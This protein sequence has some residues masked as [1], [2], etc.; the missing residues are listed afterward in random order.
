MDAVI[1]KRALLPF[2]GQSVPNIQIAAKLSR[3]LTDLLE[4]EYSVTGKVEALR[5]AELAVPERR[6]ALWRTTCFEA[7]VRPGRAKHYR[8]YNFAP[9]R[10]YAIYDFERYREGMAVADSAVPP[11]IFVDSDSDR[12]S[13]TAMVDPGDWWVAGSR[14]GLSAV[15]EDRDGGISHW[16]L[17]HPSEKPDFHDPSC[18]ALQLPA[19]KR[20]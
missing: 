13:V 19:P 4:I 8:E 7:F 5:V 9:S 20:S 1:A 18:F 3:T 11:R 15:I 10:N 17:A 2:P 16:A 14:W 12:L 6:D